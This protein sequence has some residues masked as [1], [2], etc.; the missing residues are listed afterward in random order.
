MKRHLF[1]MILCACTLVFYSCSQG[2]TSSNQEPT[3]AKSYTVH[4]GFGGEITDISTSTLTKAAAVDTDLYGIQVYSCPATNSSSPT[5]APYA[6]G[7]FDNIS[8]MTVNL[9]QGYTY[10]FACT[11]VVNGKNKLANDGNSGYWGPYFGVNNDTQLNN[12][13]IYST[14]NYFTGLAEGSSMLSGSKIYNRPNTDRYYGEITDF[15]PAENIS[16][17]IS[18][19]RVAFGAKFIAEG[20]IEGKLKISMADAPDMYIT[21]PDTTAQ[22]IYTFK[23]SANII[24]WTQD[25]YSESASTSITW[26]KADGATVPLATQDITFKRNM[27]TTI[28]VKVKDSSTKSGISLNTESTG[29]G[30]GGNVTINS[31]TGNNTPVNP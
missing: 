25:N 15:V 11:M 14:S 2:S 1:I 4:L 21:Y 17:S 29:M 30:D 9:L 19:K 23:N 26:I 10:K 5:Y 31:G 12:Q 13:F 3:T 20:L 6:Y 22:N 7:L 16:A 24:G 18:M 28:T 8:S 27:L